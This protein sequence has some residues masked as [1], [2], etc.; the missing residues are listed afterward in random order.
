[1]YCPE[2]L[3]VYGDELVTVVV[4]GGAGSVLRSLT[5]I[6]VLQSRRAGECSCNLGTEGPVKHALFALCKGIKK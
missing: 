6:P 3:I 5:Q 1:M 4:D 2:S